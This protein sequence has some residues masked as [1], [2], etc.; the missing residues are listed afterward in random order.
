MKIIKESFGLFKWLKV[1]GNE[2]ILVSE[3]QS[4]MKK[5]HNMIAINNSIALIP[6]YILE[7]IA[8]MAIGLICFISYSR[9]SEF[10][11]LLPQILLLGV[12]GIKMLPAIQQIFNG[13]ARYQANQSVINLLHND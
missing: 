3:Y 2:G 6:R 5:L 7:M 10:N 12:A 8:L 13:F 1:S 9:V 11:E 4:V